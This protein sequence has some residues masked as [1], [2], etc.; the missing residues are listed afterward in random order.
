MGLKMKLGIILL[1]ALLALSPAR[2]YAATVSDISKQFIC[3]CGCNMVLFN[4]TH[5]ECG[6]RSAMTALI[7]QKLDQGQ[8]EEQ[9]IQFFVSQYGEQ[10][11]ASPPKKGF[12]LTAWILPF[13][14]IL[15]GGLVI[16]ITLKKWV[17]RGQ[18]NLATATVEAGE[19]DENYRR[20]LEEELS[21][22]AERS[23]R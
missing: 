14:A 18:E 13:A 12:N 10:V 9:I 7:T 4:C 19:E 23:F 2:A 11:L 21:D 8:S 16:Y 15:V 6:S 17:R 22:F 3:Q 5:A 1:F 20:R